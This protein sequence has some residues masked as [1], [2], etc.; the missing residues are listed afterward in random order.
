MSPTLHHE[1]RNKWPAS[2]LPVPPPG[3]AAIHF[4]PLGELTSQVQGQAC[5]PLQNRATLTVWLLGT[6]H[7]QTSPLYLGRRRSAPVLAV[8]TCCSAAAELS[9]ERSRLP[10]QGWGSAGWWASRPLSP[11]AEQPPCPRPAWHTHLAGSAKIT[12]YEIQI[13]VLFSRD[14]NFKSGRADSD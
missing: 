5:R 4:F 6:L 9:R 10:P 8:L 3:P 14:L 11:A 2:P 13:N 1:V 12:K 7:P